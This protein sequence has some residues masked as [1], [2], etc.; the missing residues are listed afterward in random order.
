MVQF[1]EW[2]ELVKENN[3]ESKDTGKESLEHAIDIIM[4]CS[5][6]LE[7]WKQEVIFS[8]GARGYYKETVTTLLEDVSLL[9]MV[10]KGDEG[11][12][13]EDWNKVSNEEISISYI[14]KLL[15]NS[16]LC[17][18]NITNGILVKGDV[19]GL[20]ES[21]VKLPG[22]MEIS[23]GDI[24]EEYRKEYESF[25]SLEVDKWSRLR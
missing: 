25:N 24:G 2:L 19:V 7:W 12:S 21:V 3:A 10:C 15:Y 8:I 18:S 17:L 22:F 16:Y 11:L 6:L 23:A 14:L 13:V 1:K 9:L 5:K 4:G 20:L